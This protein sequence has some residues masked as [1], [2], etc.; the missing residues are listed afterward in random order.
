MGYLAGH[1]HDQ[2][3]LLPASVDDYVAADNPVRFIAAFVDDLDLDDLGLAVPV[4]KAT[5]RR[6]H[7][8]VDLLGRS[9]I[10]GIHDG[11]D[12]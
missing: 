12:L 9:D 5:G 6:G 3:L 2:M 7:D 10:L 4:P 8:P 1:S 11:L